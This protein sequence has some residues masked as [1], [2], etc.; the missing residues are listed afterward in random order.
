MIRTERRPGVT[1]ST[2]GRGVEVLTRGGLYTADAGRIVWIKR[3]NGNMG[4]QIQGE[5]KSFDGS[6]S[7]NGN[8][9]K[10]RH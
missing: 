2:F 5:K 4:Q 1:G 9:R 7:R 6:V 8:I 3:R 10:Q